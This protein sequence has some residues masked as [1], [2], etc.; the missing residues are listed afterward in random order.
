MAY[1]FIHQY[2]QYYG[3]R[4]LLRKFGIVPNAYYN[5]LKK[6]KEAYFFQKE[7]T[8]SLISEVYHSHG[9]TDGYRRVHAYLMRQ[10]IF[11][12]LQT[13]H[14]YMNTEMHLY[15]IVRKKKPDYEHG[16]QHKVFDNKLN[17]NFIATQRNQK[18]CTDFTYLFLT[19]GSRRYNCSIIDLHDR[20]VVSSITD[21]N[22]TADLAKRTLQKTIDSQPGIDISKPIYFQKIY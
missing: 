4:W 18:W 12:S 15:S 5:Y 2:G 7:K 17:Q 16:T 21:K 22:I 3:V 1:R 6:R 20:S 19:D 10:G 14:K 11:I 8:K 9:G 13:T